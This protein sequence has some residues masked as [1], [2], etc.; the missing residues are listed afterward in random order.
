MPSSNFIW[1]NQQQIFCKGAAAEIWARGG[2]YNKKPE[3][4]LTKKFTFN[5][6]GFKNLKNSK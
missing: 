2:Q 4:I 1:V 5:T 6:P 3:S